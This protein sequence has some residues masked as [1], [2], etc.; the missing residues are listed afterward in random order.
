MSLKSRLEEFSLTGRLFSLGSFL[1]NCKSIQNFIIFFHRKSFCVGFDKN[2]LGYISGDVFTNTSGR[3][4]QELNFGL[5]VA[6]LCFT[7]FNHHLY[8][9]R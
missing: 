3:R 4:A 5:S 1:E 2:G 7:Y 6:L 8:V 9:V